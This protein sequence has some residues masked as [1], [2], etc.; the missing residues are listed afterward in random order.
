MKL[1][2]IIVNYRGWKRLRPCLESLQRL[3]ELSFSWEVIVVDNR[4]SDRQLGVFV[5]D[6][7]EFYFVENAGNFGFSNGCNLGASKATGEYLLFLNPDTLITGEAVR[8][9]LREA[10]K[11]PEFT[12]L[13][14]SQVNS[15]GKDTRPYGLFLTPATLTSFLRSLYLLTHKKLKPA[16]LRSGALAIYPEW[17]S[18]SIMLISRK[19]F[20]RLGGWSED[21]WMYYEDADLC[22]RIAES[23]GK[24]VLI[25]SI[26]IIHNHGGA[27]RINL[28]VKALTKSEVII[29]RH[30]YIHKHFSGLSRLFMQSYLVINNLFIGQL[31]VALLGLLLFIKPSLRVYPRLYVNILKYYS[32]VISNKTWMS[33]RAVNY[34]KTTANKFE[35]AKAEAA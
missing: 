2:I 13:S 11:H 28:D 16:T 26:Q 7:P 10:E 32:N 35:N 20:D 27:S 34:R 18:G 23:G 3:I 9:L 5:D 12:V 25:K 8:D 24:V 30:L 1:S 15:N 31:I 4:S 17:V 29:S 21:F 33:P 6:F 22:K 19:N 14:C